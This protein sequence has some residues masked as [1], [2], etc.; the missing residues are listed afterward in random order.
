M[1]A[2]FLFLCLQEAAGVNRGDFL[3][4]AAESPRNRDAS[5]VAAK[6]ESSV[7]I[8]ETEGMLDV[9][10]MT[11]AAAMSSAAVEELARQRQALGFTMSC[12]GCNAPIKAT[13]PR[14]PSCRRAIPR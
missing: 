9:E 3:A 6:A 5:P 14:C 1:D 13:W 12:E 2:R 8:T 10:G 4:G 11:S 7:G